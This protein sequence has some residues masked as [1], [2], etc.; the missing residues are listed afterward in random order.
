MK[1]TLLLAG[2]RICFLTE[3]IYKIDPVLQNFITLEAVAPDVLVH[4]R[5]EWNRI[6]CPEVP[7][8]G[9]DRLCRYYREN[10]TWYCL[11]K[12]KVGQPLACSIYKQDLREINCYI[13]EKPFVNGT[14]NFDSILRMIPIRAVYQSFGV[15]FFHASRID[16][17]GRAILFSGPSGVGKTTQAALWHRW[18][19]AR[20]L[21][22][23]RTLVR[24]EK[25]VW[26]SYGH[27]MDGSEP[28]GSSENV[29]LRAIVL[30]HQGKENYIERLGAGKSVAR[31]MSQLVL[32]VWNTEARSKALDELLN[33][34]MD[35]PVYLLICTPDE[36]AVTIL[37]EK[38][39]KDEV[40]AG[41]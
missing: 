2:I 5:S 20:I 6:S 37:E 1:I 4:V 22:N 33:L 39:R 15:L 29:H 8:L 28:V 40:I 30:V 10:D 14:E 41:E 34:V 23:D 24:K 38:L 21:C 11:A 7:M 9:E 27:P 35:I 16:F 12:G 26:S 18:R 3:Q 19:N 25:G 36:R 13:N 17:R 31:L 32:D